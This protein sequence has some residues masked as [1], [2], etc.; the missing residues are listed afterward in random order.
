MI[1]MNETTLGF[2]WVWLCFFDPCISSCTPLTLI[3]PHR[4][5][6]HSPARPSVPASLQSPGEVVFVPGGWWHC[7]LNLET[8]VAVTQNFVSACNLGRVVRYMAEGA[9]HF[10]GQPEIYFPGTQQT[11]VCPGFCKLR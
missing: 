6:I 1:M 8:T 10:Y 5:L 9:A 4:I 3:Q 11:G 7:V 2:S